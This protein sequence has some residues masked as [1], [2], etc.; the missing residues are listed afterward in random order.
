MPAAASQDQGP[1]VR[2]V[3]VLTEAGPSTPAVA[4]IVDE[5][6]AAVVAGLPYEIQFYSESLET[7]LFPDADSQN[8]MHEWYARKYRDRKPD[9]ILAVGPSSIKFL[10][11]SRKQFFPGTPIVFCGSSKEQADNP[12]LDPTF[13][14]AWMVIEP[15]KTVEAALRLRPQTQRIAVVGGTTAYDTHVEDLVKTSLR[16]F[17][18]KVDLIDLTGLAM[19]SL[20]D[21]VKQLPE[22]TI[23]LYTSISQDSRG[24]HFD[25][26]TQSLP[27]VTGAANVPT[28]A[29]ADTLIG[30]GP[31]GGYAS[32]FRLQGQVAAEDTIKVLQ[33][34]RP[35]DIPIVQG[36]SVYM[37]DWRE[38]KRWKANE[39]SLPQ[40]SI[41]L[42]PQ[43]SLW[44]EHKWTIIAI[45]LATFLLILFGGYLLIERWRRRVAESELQHEM[46]FERLISELS[47]YLID[48][49]ADQVDSGIDS[50]LNRVA[51]SQAMDRIS[52]LEFK[53][54]GRELQTTHSTGGQSSAMLGRALKSEDFPY[55]IGKLSKN[56]ILV[57]SN[58]EQCLGMS[59]DERELLRGRG[60]RAGIFV[61]LE[62]REVVL[63]VLAFVSQQERQWPQK[64]I[65]QCCMLA[66]TFAN[67]L[68]RNRA[69]EALLTS[70]LLKSAILTSLSS[71][72]VVA[73]RNGEILSTNSSIEPDLLS[74]SAD[75]APEFRVGANCLEI[76]KRST[77]A[78]NAIASEIVDGINSVLE[79]RRPRFE[80]E[81]ASD[82]EQGRKWILTSVT[83]LKMRQG[84]VVITHTEITNRKQAEEER[85]ELSGRLIDMQE[86]ERSRLAREL[87]DDFNQRLAILAIDL[88]R[89]SQ[90]ISDS[91]IETRQRL[92]ELWNRA[93]IIGTDLHS[94]S[95]RLHSSTL[96]SLGLVLG[97]S[98]L[99][100]EFAEQNGI[101]V[102]FTHENI[103]RYV[104]SDIALC[105]FRVAQEGLRNVKR[106]SGASRAEVRL[107]AA[108][109]VI[110][111]SVSDEG[112]GFNPR[113][114]RARAGLGIRSMQERLRLL[115]GHFEIRSQPGE[116][117]VIHVSIP[118]RTH[119]ASPPREETG[120]VSYT[121]A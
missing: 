59:V 33:G 21:R 50:A 69:D 63:G 74:R 96:E 89:A 88:E 48:L 119:A 35:E 113:L 34:T 76:F 99:C 54:D 91:P 28:F 3:L 72:V 97:V 87:H 75:S 108:E 78:G 9:L 32:S 106:H 84:G 38:L 19:P 121:Q 45:S 109:Q 30:H 55:A 53:K 22:N 44:R 92:H 117:T 4:V 71:N 42:Y 67:A 94:F 25:N 98:S 46:N 102:D 6:H 16:N 2:R 1:E 79:G 120:E 43:P 100:S 62:A 52:M 80:L 14:G 83:P 7:T 57:L 85:L 24:T 77:N 60:I 116:G 23:I 13:T 56:E 31:V 37:F 103:S 10:A 12:V 73:D 18:S 11:G 65:E 82:F 111:L 41:I 49:P 61:P 93:S 101:Q 27:A 66:Q 112:I 8:E 114:S 86:K 36:T 40:G 68:V 115:E 47:T 51:G 81:W 110:S 20:L 26:T 29:M 5:I 104:S 107:K 64:I 58:L 17:R 15:E 39:D 105:L 70:E 90:T 95:H 118:L